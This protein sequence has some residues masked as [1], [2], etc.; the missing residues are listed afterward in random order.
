MEV[1]KNGGTPSYHP[2]QIGIFRYNHQ[3]ERKC[4]ILNQP[5]IGGTP[6]TMETVPHLHLRHLAL[7]RH[8]QLRA[9]LGK[10]RL[11]QQGAKHV[12]LAKKGLEDVP[13]TNSL[14]WK[15]AIEIVDLPIKNGE[16]P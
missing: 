15:M 1:S 2:F 3:F 16:F 6:T 4:S 10:P 8:V 7:Q 5:A 14:L 12:V 9:K 11:A 13:L